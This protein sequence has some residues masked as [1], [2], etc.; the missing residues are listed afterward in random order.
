MKI[1]IKNN[2]K[3]FKIEAMSIVISKNTDKTKKSRA[4]FGLKTDSLIEK[5]QTIS[6]KFKIRISH[7]NN[8]KFYAKKQQIRHF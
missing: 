4:N 2:Q 8:K 6:M 3:L 1:I 7:S 5:Y